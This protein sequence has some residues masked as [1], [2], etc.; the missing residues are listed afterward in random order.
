LE[1][2]FDRIKELEELNA[3]LETSLGSTSGQR[4][5]LREQVKRKDDLI[6]ELQRQLSQESFPLREGREC[7]VITTGGHHSI[8]GTTITSLK[9]LP[10]PDRAL[11]HRLMRHTGIRGIRLEH[12]PDGG[13]ATNPP[14]FWFVSAPD[15]GLKGHLYSKGKRSHR[16]EV[17]VDVERGAEQSVIRYAAREGLFG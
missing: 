13:K 6:R 8:W 15:G 11:F 10:G 17:F 14:K 5:I 2:A 12:Y 3:S 7:S 1:I 4:K 9:D 16:C